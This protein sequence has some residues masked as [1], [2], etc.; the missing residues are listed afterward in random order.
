MLKNVNVSGTPSLD[1]NPACISLWG[2]GP[3][4]LLPGVNIRWPRQAIWRN[5]IE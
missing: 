1:V 4:Q 3:G 2:T 5:L